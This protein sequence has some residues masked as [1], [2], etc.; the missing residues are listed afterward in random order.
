MRN[1]LGFERYRTQK[2]ISGGNPG[3]DRRNTRPNQDITNK[4]VPIPLS[5]KVQYIQH[6][7][8]NHQLLH[9]RYPNIR[10]LI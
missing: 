3:W 8:I 7:Q 1:L 4:M 5:G 9:L 2:I 6:R 10:R